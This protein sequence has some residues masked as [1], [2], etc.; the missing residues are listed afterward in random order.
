ME[1]I[2]LFLIFVVFV[3]LFKSSVSIEVLKQAT[4]DMNTSVVW[5]HFG[6][7]RYIDKTNKEIEKLR[8]EIFSLRQELEELKNKI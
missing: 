1:W 8:K 3:W 2:L 4:E 6:G 5:R 7:E